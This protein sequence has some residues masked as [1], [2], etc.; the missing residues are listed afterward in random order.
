MNRSAQEVQRGSPDVGVWLGGWLA[1]LRGR[2][3]LRRG[4][5]RLRCLSLLHGR[6][7]RHH[8]DIALAHLAWG[9]AAIR[10]SKR[11]QRMGT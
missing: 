1:G 7:G 3:W 4:R 11:E 8:G 5:H 9:K 6:R 10:N 2:L